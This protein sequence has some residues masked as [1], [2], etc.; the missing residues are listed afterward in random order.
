[1]EYFLRQLDP[2]IDNP[3]TISLDRDE[4][5]IGRQLQPFLLG[6]GQLSR[7]HARFQKVNNVWFVKDLKSLNGV[8]V[9]GARVNQEPRQLQI[10]DVI[11][12]GVPNIIKGAFVV[13]LSV[14]NP[15]MNIIK[16]EDDDDD[17]V[18]I[19]EIRNDKYVSYPL[20]N[21]KETAQ[22]NSSDNIKSACQTNC[23]PSET[24]ASASIKP[25]CNTDIEKSK[26]DSSSVLRSQQVTVHCN[27]VNA[28]EISTQQTSFKEKTSKLSKCK[29]QNSPK[30]ISAELLKGSVNP[31]FTIHNSKLDSFV[32]NDDESIT[33]VTETSGNL[34]LPPL[35]PGRKIQKC[36]VDNRSDCQRNCVSPSLPSSTSQEISTIPSVKPSARKISVEHINLKEKSSDLNKTEI[37]NSDLEKIPY[38]TLGETELTAHNSKLSMSIFN[39]SKPEITE[40]SLESEH[41]EK[42]LLKRKGGKKESVQIRDCYV[43]LVKC[44]SKYFHLPSGIIVG[45]FDCLSPVE[46]STAVKTASASN[47]IKCDM[48]RKNS[49]DFIS[50]GVLPK[51]LHLS[52]DLPTENMQSATVGAKSV[53]RDKKEENFGYSQEEEVIYISDDDS[54][55][56]FNS[57]QVI[58]KSEPVDDYDEIDV[59]QESYISEKTSVPASSFVAV[60]NIDD[61]GLDIIM[62][63]EEDFDV[64]FR[65]NVSAKEENSETLED[66]IKFV[67]SK[68]KENSENEVK[69]GITAEAEIDFFPELS[70]NFYAEDCAEDNILA[71]KYNQSS[72]ASTENSKNKLVRKSCGRT[73]LTDPKPMEIRSRKIRGREEGFIERSKD[74]DANLDSVSQK[75]K[76]KAKNDKNLS[77][78]GNKATKPSTSDFIKV[79]SNKLGNF[80]IPKKANVK[81][82][83]NERNKE[84][85]SGQNGSQKLQNS[86]R[87]K[88]PPIPRRADNYGSRLGSLVEDMQKKK[89][90][91]SR[92]SA[93]IKSSPQK[94]KKLESSRINLSNVYKQQTTVEHFSKHNDISVQ[95]TA[96]KD[97]YASITQN[98]QN[99]H[100]QVFRQSVRLVSD[101]SQQSTSVTS[102]SGKSYISE[103]GM[104]FVKSDGL[105]SYVAD[106]RLKRNVQK[107]RGQLSNK[108]SNVEMNE[109]GR[110]HFKISMQNNP[111]QTQGLEKNSNSVSR[112]K[113]Y[114]V[115]EKV[116]GL[117]VKW[118]EEQ[119]K[120]KF[121]PPYVYEGADHLPLHFD[122]L[123]KYVSSFSPMLMLEL[124]DLIC[125][126][127]AP[128]IDSQNSRNKFYFEIVSSKFEEGMTKL[129]CRSIINKLS[130]NP[131]E[132]NLIIMHIQYQNK[133]KC[134]NPIFGYINKFTVEELTP[135]ILNSDV[136][137]KMPPQWLT[138][139]K[140]CSF[141]VYVKRRHMQPK[142][143]HL[144]K[145]NGICSLRNRLRLADCLHN[146]VFSP[147]HMDIICPRFETFFVNYRSGIFPSRDFNFS[148][149]QFIEGVATDLQCSVQK[150]KIILLQGP[151]GAGKTHTIIG[152]IEE[153][154]NCNSIKG[155]ILITAPSNAAVDEIGLRLVKL[156]KQSKWQS[157]KVTFVRIGQPAQ[158]HPEILKYFLDEK[159]FNLYHEERQTNIDQKRKELKDL[160]TKIKQLE[161][162]MRNAPDNASEAS[163]NSLKSQWQ[164]KYSQFSFKG[165]AYS[166]QNLYRQKVLTESKIVLSTLGSCG[167]SILHMTFKPN[168]RS[169]F[170]CCIVDEATQCTELE[171]LQPLLFQMD[172]LILVGDH[173]QLPATV[174]SKL[175]VE[176]GFER[177][178]FERF[179][180]YFKKNFHDSPLFMLREQYRMHSQICHF[181]SK[182]FY[183]GNLITSPETDIRDVYFK[184]FPYLVY[185]VQDSLESNAANSKANQYEAFSIVK[186][187]EQLLLIDS[188]MPIGIITPYQGQLAMY[189]NCVNN[190]PAWKT[191]EVNTVDGFQGREKDVIIFSSVR[192]NN[193]GN[194]GFVS[195]KKR[196]NVAIT[197]ARKCLIIC[198]HMK[199]LICDPH[200]KAL[201]QDARERRVYYVVNSYK[202][203]PLIFRKAIKSTT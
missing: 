55:L 3:I 166:V 133:D 39:N 60:N 75:R 59:E 92:K 95:K 183:E 19:I 158:M 101:V 129:L 90:P 118:L 148:Q 56:D 13:S 31:E 154:L 193:S 201:I 153:I 16:Q 64:P 156:S 86:S 165:L 40:F 190:S 36:P 24:S 70:Q 65:N 177:S 150:P 126:E 119:K 167:Q 102:A 49:S 198:G 14:R 47:G 73:L 131:V 25:C 169:F 123:D 200:W 110:G 93:S 130:F 113:F 80:K 44:D 53:L 35:V 4:I 199:S 2:E 50:D 173:Q 67:N 11:G 159:A 29:V 72:F 197:R 99:S 7:Y 51:K 121:P 147:L 88:K 155:K 176:Y 15:P 114:T 138:S 100:N 191:I 43:P 170:S 23:L 33:Q 12:F 1:M 76:S 132:G 57:S 9:N 194:I 79:A 174:N 187:C 185:D 122:S 143:K 54:F 145:A 81:H 179:H 134:S 103:N 68:Y 45:N 48:K 97:S 175:A 117:N 32:S 6:Y 108:H 135:D 171:M 162:K 69:K 188:K 180:V 127:S 5:T 28:E 8:Y 112:I 105:P 22:P 106:P 46:I 30:N 17:D 83:E 124:W 42:C 104:P 98:G 91:Q 144:M 20:P 137:R 139:A 107:V 115:L 184:V 161:E 77:K 202:D 94:L 61:D 172:K 62:E 74:C 203:I 27:G 34:F 164:N 10:G 186:I 18:E 128:I 189:K 84:Q 141:S 82:D 37:L 163:L 58:I 63:C 125:Q 182:Y 195:S 192:A 157:E 120:I 38:V 26:G 87:D 109:K 152:L 136:W 196:L 111:H 142:Y 160:E 181:P 140:L 85:T 146:I 52:T 178:M 41:Y 66:I 71:N 89:P 78:K 151:P 149:M 21:K 168:P 116:L 96:S